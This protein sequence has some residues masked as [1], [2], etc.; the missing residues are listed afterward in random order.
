MDLKKYFS[1]VSKV[2]LTFSSKP[3]IEETVDKF[4]SLL[5]NSILHIFNNLVKY[6]VVSI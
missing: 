2:S 6:C 3:N 1:R 5:V 4:E